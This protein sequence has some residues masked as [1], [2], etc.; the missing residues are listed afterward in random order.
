MAKMSRNEYDRYK[1]IIQSFHYGSD[2][3]Q[4]A[5]ARLQG[6]LLAF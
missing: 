6:K 4:D 2:S 1:E 3:S 5:K